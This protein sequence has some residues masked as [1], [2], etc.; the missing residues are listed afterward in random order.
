MKIRS[1]KSVAFSAL[2]TFPALLIYVLVM[3]LV[4]RQ[5]KAAQTKRQTSTR[6]PCLLTSVMK[7]K[8]KKIPDFPRNKNAMSA[9]SLI[10]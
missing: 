9:M 1:S 4:K 2:R 8:L 5:L 6:H 7:P 10:S 3:F